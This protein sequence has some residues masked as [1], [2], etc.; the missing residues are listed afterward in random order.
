MKKLLFIF[1]IS[2]HPVITPQPVSALT[3]RIDG[4]DMQIINNNITV[5]TSIADTL[6]LDRTIKSGVGK[7][8][9]FTVEL[10]RVWKFWP[11]EFVV[12]KKARKFVKYDNLR[13][14][15][16]ASLHDGISRADV[17][18]NDFAALK[19]W[20]FTSNDVN[21]ANIRELDPGHYY[22][23]VVVESRS[24]EQMPLIGFIM[25]LMPEVEMSLAKESRSFTVGMP[26]K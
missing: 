16:L 2:L 12:S 1:L 25:H 9:I 14:Q 6:D 8:I 24:M 19:D 17:K 7:E 22:I 13:D 26:E 18:F 4:P 5:K 21:L 10:I 23:R 3:P 20:L 15:Y 11:D